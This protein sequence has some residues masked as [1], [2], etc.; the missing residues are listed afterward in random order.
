MRRSCRSCTGHVQITR[1]EAC[2]GRIVYRA[3]GRSSRSQMGE[4]MIH[5][6][7]PVMLALFLAC[8]PLA[9][10]GQTTKPVD[11]IATADRLIDSGL[12]YLKSKQNADGSWGNADD[13][14]GL[15]ALALRSFAEAGRTPANDADVARGYKKLTVVSARKW[16]NLQRSAG[17]LQHGHRAQRAGGRR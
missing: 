7:L 14:P 10:R 8:Q 1:D 13:P 6:R 4:K 5:R 11:A 12:A 15:T 17:Q 16:R 2:L 9:G 3:I